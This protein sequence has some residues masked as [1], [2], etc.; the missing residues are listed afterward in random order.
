MKEDLEYVSEIV[1]TPR[2]YVRHQFLDP[3]RENRTLTNSLQHKI[4]TCKPLVSNRR[5]ATT[6]SPNLRD[7]LCPA[8]READLTFVSN[9]LVGSDFITHGGRL[10]NKW[11]SAMQ[12]ISPHLFDKLEAS[13][14]DKKGSSN[15]RILF[16]SV[17]EILAEKLRPQCYEPWTLRLSAT[18]VRT[19]RRLV[20]DVWNEIYKRQFPACCHDLHDDYLESLVA[21]DLKTSTEWMSLHHDVNSVCLQLEKAIFSDMITEF[22]RGLLV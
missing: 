20:E 7:L 22:C 2:V 1:D 13:H 19:G 21:Q 11:H 8:G 5:F 10:I 9:I 3:A 12:P 14:S 6:G 15:R 4:K 16:D 18:A 17:N